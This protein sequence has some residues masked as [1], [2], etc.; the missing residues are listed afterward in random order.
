[1]QAKRRREIRKGITANIL[2]RKIIFCLLKNN[3][4]QHPNKET[5]PLILISRS[6]HLPSKPDP[7]NWPGPTWRVTDGHHQMANWNQVCISKAV[8]VFGVNN[9][10]KIFYTRVHVW[11]HLKIKSNWKYFQFD[12]K[13]SLPTRKIIFVLIFPSN[14]FRNYSLLTHSSHTCTNLISAPTHALTSTPHTVRRQAPA[15]QPSQAHQAPARFTLRSHQDCT[16]RTNRTLGS[17]RDHTLGSHR[18][19]WDRT[20]LSLSR[21]GAVVLRRYWSI[22]HSLFLLSIWPNLMNFFWLGFVSFVFIYWEIV[23]Y[24]CLE[25]EKMWETS[26][27]CFI[28]YYFQEHNQTLENIFQSIFWNATKHLKIFSFPKNIFTWKYFTFNQTQPK[29]HVCGHVPSL[30]QFH[31]SGRWHQTW[32]NSTR[33]QPYLPPHY[34]SEFFYVI[35]FKFLWQ[36]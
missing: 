16:D 22:S 33:G 30:T 10:R 36:N 32:T 8:F 34:H 17:H 2:T 1:M 5:L 13:Y 27:K 23:L 24:I 11:H 28:L 3:H 4:C 12:Q 18:L 9:F 25:A 14:D 7:H 31:L 26:R 15:T 35:I 29:N 20:N 21:S 19:H 6:I